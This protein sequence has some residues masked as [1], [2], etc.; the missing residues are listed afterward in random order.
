MTKGIDKLSAML[1]EAGLTVTFN[2]SPVPP[3]SLEA[4]AEASLARRYSRLTVERAAVLFD[5]VIYSVPRPQR[6]DAALM[7]LVEKFG[8][9]GAWRESCV[10]GF[11]L[12][13]G[14][15]ADRWRALIVA[16]RAG[17]TD[18]GA[19]ILISEDLW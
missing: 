8:R 10:S 9:D 2:G 3:E 15:F 19:E 12:S 16:R 14:S 1:R 4:V 18:S 13:D 11:V 5:D 7:M 17:Q 6:H